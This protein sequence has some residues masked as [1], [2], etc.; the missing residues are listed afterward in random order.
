VRI[1]ASD[2]S[3][4][5]APVPRRQSST[6]C[7]ARIVS[8]GRLDRDSAQMNIV[9]ALGEDGDEARIV[10]P[11][12]R[13]S[14]EAPGLAQGSSVFAQIKSVA[15]LASGGETNRCRDPRTERSGDKHARLLPGMSATAVQA[16]EPASARVRGEPARLSSAGS[17]I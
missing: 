12:T 1:G 14:Q 6:A 4:A 13:K 11:V 3:F 16:A 10:G 9:A 5:R 17:P 7:P 8:V 2:V 15:L